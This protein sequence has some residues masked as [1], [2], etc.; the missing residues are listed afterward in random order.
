M[1]ENLTGIVL[2]LSTLTALDQQPAANLTIYTGDCLI[3]HQGQIQA[4]EIGQPLFTG[5]SVLTG[6]GS[7]AELSF[8]DGTSIRI[9]EQCR[10]AVDQADTLRSLKLLWGKL[11]AK[12]AKMSSS[13]TR[14]Q[15]ET[16]TAVAGVRGTIFRVEVETDSATKVAV[17][18]GEVEIYDARLSPRMLRLSA[19]QQALFRRGRFPS[20]PKAYDPSKQPRWERWSGKA[21]HA[22]ERRLKY[23]E[24]LLK[25][26]E[27]L[28]AAGGRT[29]K[30]TS[31]EINKLKRRLQ[32]D[33]RQWQ[34]LLQRGEFGLRQ[35]LTLARRVETDGDPS[36][37]EGQT[38]AAKDHLEAL[39]RRRQELEDRISKSL[40]Q[41]DEDSRLE[42]PDTGFSVLERMTR[43][44]SA[45][46]A[47]Q[48]R[49]EALG[50]NLDAVTAKLT[51]YMAQIK[52]IRQLYPQHPLAA[53]EKFFRLRN[54]YYSFK[55]QHHG[56]VY[57]EMEREAADRQKAAVWAS[58]MARGID[59]TDPQF[60]ETLRRQQEIEITGQKYREALFQ[61]RQIRAAARMV[62]RQLVDIGGLIR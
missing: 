46:R 55:L 9:S 34:I 30:P 23:L 13:K 4:A 25:S 16:P 43:L 40:E 59:R 24:S 50:S 15:V 44:A 48:S 42:T 45:S 18:E 38:N 19:R 21:L 51:E 1:L 17:E 8:V 33:Q 12:V 58:K 39:I 22:I 29:K 14:F 2:L 32:D 35:L 5:D 61:T 57:Q 20:G 53:R 60:E 36:V 62:E 11:W 56:F 3:W 49:L 26:A 7:K 41:L 28:N 10:L 52:E 27:K 6:K 31:G 37:L 54:D 47:A